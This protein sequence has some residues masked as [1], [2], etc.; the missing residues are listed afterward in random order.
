MIKSLKKNN[1][2]KI[3]LAAN[4]R[5]LYSAKNVSQTIP[6]VLFQYHS[7][8]SFFFYNMLVF[9]TKLSLHVIWAFNDYYYSFEWNLIR[10]K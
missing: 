5:K 8:K 3:I 9:T 10:Q 1:N 2:L 6:Y 4:N 7:D